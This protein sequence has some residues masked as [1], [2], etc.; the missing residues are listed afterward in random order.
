M[1]LDELK[2]KQPG[3]MNVDEANKVIKA[4]NGILAL[5]SNDANIAEFVFNEKGSTLKFNVILIDT[6]VCEVDA[7][8]GTSLKRAQVLGNILGPYT[9]P[10]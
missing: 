9:A 3:L 7:A 10:E 4:I 6:V 5:Q 1:S 2:K 8:G